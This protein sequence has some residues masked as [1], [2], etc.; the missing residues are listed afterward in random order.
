MRLLARAILALGCALLPA[1][2]VADTMLLGVR[3]PQATVVALRYSNTERATAVVQVTMDD[4]E[5]ECDRLW[6]GKGS[7]EDP[8]G[9]EEGRIAECLEGY[10]ERE[11]DLLAVAANCE[12]GLLRASNGAFLR[13]VGRGEFGLVWQNVATGEGAGYGSA[14]P[15]AVADEQ[16][17]ALCDA[18]VDRL[19]DELPEM[20]DG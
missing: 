17:A 6:K 7:D 9:W 1:V 16:F 10:A 4:I 8:P 3:G 5:S 19:K 2:A 11:G 18:H 15:A 20:E 14:S 12:N 13:A